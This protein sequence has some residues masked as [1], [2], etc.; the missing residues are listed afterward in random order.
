[1]VTTTDLERISPEGHTVTS[2]AAERVGWTTRGILLSRSSQQ[3][4]L[5][6]KK[7]K[8]SSIHQI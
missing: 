1:M 4:A 3:S 5:Q 6:T 7:K 8:V 2:H